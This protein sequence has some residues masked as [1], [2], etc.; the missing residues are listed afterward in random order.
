LNAYKKKVEGKEMNEIEKCKGHSSNQQTKNEF[1]KQ[2][3]AVNHTQKE[4]T[5][6]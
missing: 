3:A 6:M 5:F 4:N 2:L 1:H